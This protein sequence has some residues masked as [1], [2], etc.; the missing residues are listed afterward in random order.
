MTSSGEIT[1]GPYVFTRHDAMRTLGNLDDLWSSMMAWRTST[2]ADELGVALRQRLAED[3]ALDVALADTWATLRA[4]TDALRAEG[5]LPATATGK[6]T[7]LSVSNGGVPKLAVDAVA[8]G[9]RGLEGDAQRVRV[10]H[11]RP[12]QAL[13]IYS[14]EVIDMLCGEG[15]PI[16]RGS[17]GE[18]VT[19]AGLDWAEV[20]PGVVLEIGGVLAHVQSYAAPCSTNAQFFLGGDFN[21]M[22]VNRGPVSRVYAT[23]LRPGRIATGDPVVLEPDVKATIDELTAAGRPYISPA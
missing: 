23:V 13:C 22:N 18:N 15:H 20:R 10:H 12:W 11:G 9:F 2:T 8:V 5:Q 19:V 6:V 3:P 21:R 7:Q 1:I 16:G 17:V 4:A 14:D